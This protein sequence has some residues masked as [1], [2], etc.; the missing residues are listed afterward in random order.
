[1]THPTVAAARRFVR[2]YGFDA[3]IVA[4][5]SLA[6]IVEIIAL[7]AIWP[8]SWPAA[9]Q[10]SLV[11]ALL[12]TLGGAAAIVVK[13][14]FDRIQLATQYSA[15]VKQ[16]L[17]ESSY[18]Y[19]CDYLMPLASHAGF[20]GVQMQEYLDRRNASVDTASCVDSM[21]YSIAL[22]MRVEAA[23]RAYIPLADC[24]PPLGLF[25]SSD[26]AEDRVWD[27]V[28]PGWAFGLP[29]IEYTG[30]LVSALYA[31]PSVGGQVRLRGPDE[32][33]ALSRQSDHPLKF[34]RDA[35]YRKLSEIRFPEDMIQ[36]LFALTDIVNYEVRIVFRE[37][38]SG[39][40]VSI[41]DSYERAYKLPLCVRKDLGIFQNPLKQAPQDN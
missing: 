24:P 41:P 6:L 36:A 5:T 22:Y 3:V 20:I 21:L 26:A 38:Y 17:V 37:W 34:V 1:V 40:E 9:A 15:N 23:L 31:S 13:A 28:M 27:L 11:G 18:Q 39:E 32:F 33:I 14:A 10:A 8:T 16:K 4:V 35:V 7:K 29:N 2:R 19:A 12:T 25:L 30:V